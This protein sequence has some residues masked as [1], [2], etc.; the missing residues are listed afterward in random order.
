MLDRRVV[1]HRP[2]GSERRKPT[3]AMR[4]RWSRSEFATNS[5][6]SYDR[7]EQGPGSVDNAEDEAAEHEAPETGTLTVTEMGLRLPNRLALMRI[8]MVRM[9]HQGR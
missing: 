4:R 9:R 7:L 5:R 2:V 6:C 1:R 8:S 3:P